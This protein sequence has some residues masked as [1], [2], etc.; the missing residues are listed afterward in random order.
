MAVFNNYKRLIGIILK[1]KVILC[2]KTGL[3]EDD[4]PDVKFEVLSKYLF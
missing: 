2:Q 1:N 3:T 4:L